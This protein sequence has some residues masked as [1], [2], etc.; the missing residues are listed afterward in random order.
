M[1][2]TAKLDYFYGKQ[3]GESSFYQIPKELFT[4]PRLKNLSFEAKFLYSYLV[5][6][7][8]Q[9]AKNNWI[10]EEGR[11]FIVISIN[12]I[13]NAIG[14]C[15][16]TVV[17]R[18]TE[19]DARKGAGLIEKKRCGQGKANIVY[20]KRFVS[21]EESERRKGTTD[22]QQVPKN[23]TSGNLK[24]RRQEVQKTDGNYIDINNNTGSS[25]TNINKNILSDLSTGD[26]TKDMMRMER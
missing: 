20:V 14:C 5:D 6:Q 7:M 8:S 24:S 13:C 19:L 10:D 21:G 16:Q 9:S 15:R 11:A 22:T 4:D 23:H 12:E 25:E 2:Q 17:N 1:S 26:Y 3:A 18:M